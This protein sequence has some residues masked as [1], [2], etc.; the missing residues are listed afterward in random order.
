MIQRLYHELTKDDGLNT[1]PNEAD[2]AARLAS[3]TSGPGN[4]KGPDESAAAKLTSKDK[5]FLDGV[6]FKGE[7]IKAGKCRLYGL[8]WWLHTV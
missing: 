8:L 6:N 2:K 4:V 5:I 3:V 7:I 1:L